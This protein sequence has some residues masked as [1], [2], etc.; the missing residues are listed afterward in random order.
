M[1]VVEERH[2]VH[3]AAFSL[4]VRDGKVLLHRRQNTGYRDGQYGLPAGHVEQEETAQEACVRELREETG[5]L[6]KLEDVE[7]VHVCHNWDDDEYINIF[8]RVRAWEGEPENREPDMCAEVAW[9]PLHDL[10][11]NTMPYIRDM[12]ERVQRGEFYSNWRRAR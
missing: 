11:E 2:M 9:Y 10:P 1:S 6:A 4:L 3:I 7:I 8:G 5:L 12:L